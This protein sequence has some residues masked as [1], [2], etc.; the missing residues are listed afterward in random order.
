MHLNYGPCSLRE[1]FDMTLEFKKEC[2]ITQLQSTFND[3][4][5]CYEE[6]PEQYEFSMEEVQMRSQMQ[7]QGQGEYQQGNHLSIRRGNT[8]TM[9]AKSLIKGTITGPTLTKDTNHSIIRDQNKIKA[10]TPEYERTPRS[11]S[12]SSNA[13]APDRL[14]S[15]ATIKF[16]TRTVCG[17]I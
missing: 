15:C 9:V 7:G 1:A 17:D 10:I 14:W 6:T 4:E 5:T 3:M 16:H 12:R 2:Q 13:A 11:R 8:I